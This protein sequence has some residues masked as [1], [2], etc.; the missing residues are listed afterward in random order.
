MEVTM[1]QMSSVH[2]QTSISRLKTEVQFHL[3]PQ[4]KAAA[5]ELHKTLLRLI[6]Q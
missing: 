1:D 2:P 5:P 6:S 4:S 3:R